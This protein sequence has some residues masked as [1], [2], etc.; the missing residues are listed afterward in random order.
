MF[1]RIAGKWVVVGLIAG[2]AGAAQAEGFDPR[3]DCSILLGGATEAEQVMIAAWT[4]GYLAANADNVRPVDSQNN[5]VL[6]GNIAKACQANAGAS[7]LDIVSANSKPAAAAPVPSAGPAPGSEAEARAL[8]MQYFEPGANYLALTQ[9]LLPT[10]AD[11][12][13]VYAEPLGSALWADLSSQ[14]GPGTAF[15]PKPDHN[16]IIVVH[17]TTRALAEKRPVL[18]EFPGGY[19]DVLQYFKVDVPIVRFKFVTSGDTLGLAF[20]GLIYLN[21]R[22]VIMPK[23]W[24]SLPG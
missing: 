23:P 20:D 22:W 12:R 5:G 10:E 11:V 19:K 6:L 17:T 21:G 14:I 1:Y 8:L 4:F 2:L 13:A 18:N 7:L 3:A 16:D 24:R 9:A 15:G